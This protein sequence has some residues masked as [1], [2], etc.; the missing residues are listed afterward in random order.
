MRPNRVFLYLVVVIGILGILWGGY[1]L[2]MVLVLTLVL[3]TIWFL[4]S[5][6]FPGVR[7][8]KTVAVAQPLLAMRMGRTELYIIRRNENI[9]HPEYE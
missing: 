7:T 8:Y 3:G 5:R 6:N 9:S 4:K 1:L 2:G